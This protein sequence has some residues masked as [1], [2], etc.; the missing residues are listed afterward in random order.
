MSEPP[1]HEVL[2]TYRELAGLT[3]QQLANHLGCSAA[4]V[5]RWACG[6]ALP[7]RE[8]VEQLEQLLNAGGKIISA[9]RMG[10]SGKS[11]PEWARPLLNIEARARYVQAASPTLVPGYLQ[12]PLY[13]GAV[14]RAWHPA[15][16][17]SEIERLAQIRTQRLGQLPELR[18]TAVFPVYGITGFDGAVRAEQA[19]HLVEL[20]EQGRLRVHLVPEGAILLSVTSPVLVFRLDTG[21]TVISSDHIYGNVVYDADRNDQLAALVTGAMAEALPARLSLQALKELA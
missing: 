15:A 18:I 9:W 16:S 2:T 6:H 14:F 10:K 5:S 19:R 8:T 21:E 7:F 17:D 12:S 11:T 3:Q 13:A 4:S 1:F 20:T